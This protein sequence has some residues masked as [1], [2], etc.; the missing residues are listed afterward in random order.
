MVFNVEAVETAQ[1]GPGKGYVLLK[2]GRFGYTKEYISAL[3]V[4]HL[5]VVK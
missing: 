5:E 2:N 4:G 1:C 3:F